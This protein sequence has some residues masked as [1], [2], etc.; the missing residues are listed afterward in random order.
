MEM[1]TKQQKKKLLLSKNIKLGKVYD[2]VRAAGPEVY[3]KKGFALVRYR[4][5]GKTVLATFCE[6][7]TVLKEYPTKLYELAVG[8]KYSLDEL[9]KG[10]VAKQK[11]SKEKTFKN[12]ENKKPEKADNVKLKTFSELNDMQQ[13]LYI[14]NW[15]AKNSRK[16]NSLMDKKVARLNKKGK[17][18]VLTKFILNKKDLPFE[19]DSWQGIAKAICENSA[20]EKFDIKKFGIR[21]FVD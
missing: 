15:Y 12:L 11:T 20:F 16:L 17:Q 2:F 9:H 18:I 3:E 19:E 14:K 21:F 6:D 13:Q 5:N 8:S 7:G 4:H 1:N 10:H